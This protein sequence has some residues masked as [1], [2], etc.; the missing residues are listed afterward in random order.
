MCL[1][2]GTPFVHTV[3]SCLSQIGNDSTTMLNLPASLHKWIL[4]AKVQG[5]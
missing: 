4:G 5:Q 1:P 3:S 2:I